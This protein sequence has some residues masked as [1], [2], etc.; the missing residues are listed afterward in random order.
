MQKS[1]VGTE[2]YVF[3]KFTH[4]KELQ[5]QDGKATDMTIISLDRAQALELANRLGALAESAQE[6]T[7]ELLMYTSD[8]VSSRTGKP[9]QSTTIA[10]KEA[11]PMEK[12]QTQKQWGSKPQ[13]RF[14]G[15]GDGPKPAAKIVNGYAARQSGFQPRV[16]SAVGGDSDI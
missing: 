10:V 15:G 14:G 6:E 4:K 7:L 2:K 16:R 11:R 9:F 3:T 13:S 12:A 5:G 8:R 1:N